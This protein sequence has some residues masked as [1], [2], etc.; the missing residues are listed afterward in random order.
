[1]LKVG[2]VGLPNAGKSTLFNALVVKPKASTAPY[3]FTTIEKN[4]GAVTVPDELLFQLAKIEN[5]SKVTPTTITFIDIAGLI[6]GA[7]VGEGLGNQFLHHIREV[8]LILHLLRFFKNPDIPHI[9]PHID[10]EEDA[11]IVNEE[12]LLAD[13][14]SLEKK[15]T[16]EKIIAEEKQILKKLI[17]SLNQG[18]MAYQVA[19]ED[20]KKD[21]FQSLNLLTAKKQL[22][23]ANIDEKDLK[24]P[25]KTFKG[26]PI[27][28]ICAKLEADLAEL[29]WVEQQ[30]FLKE[31]GLSK[32]AKENIILE[33]YRALEIITFYTIAKRTEAKAWPL[34]KGAKAIEA[35]A[36]I[37]T[38]F[39]KHFVKVETINAEELI[40]IGSWQKAHQE[41]KIILAGKDYLLKDKDVLE[42]KVAMKSSLV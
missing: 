32:S 16:K 18:K 3:P 13:L 38:D 41:G 30:R 27:L 23:V 6:K 29:P 22:Y 9:H 2:I 24:N 36:K 8:D 26:K 33:S 7:S 10:P 28:S 40:K 17:D 14:Q 19:I 39:A 37:H 12:L 35:A 4:T 34:K 5:I 11:E 1:M 25:P 15:I 21:F 31:Y 20:K 42:F